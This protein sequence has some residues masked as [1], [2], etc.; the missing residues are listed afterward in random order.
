MNDR[1][2]LNSAG[3]P[4]GAP[5]SPLKTRFHAFNLSRLGQPGA[6]AAMWYSKHRKTASG[7]HR[8]RG[9]KGSADGV[10]EI[11]THFPNSRV[12]LATEAVG[13]LYLYLREHPR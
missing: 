13:G 12:A 1:R 7:A 4:S 11:G 10:V 2:S 5:G 3:C 8:H 9:C 6:T